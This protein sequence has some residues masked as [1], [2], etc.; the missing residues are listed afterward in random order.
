MIRGQNQISHPPRATGDVDKV[1][2]APPLPAPIRRILYLASEG[3]QQVFHRAPR[4][5]SEP[6]FFKQAFRSS[7]LPAAVAPSKAAH[8][9]VSLTSFPAFR[10]A[11]CS[12]L[13]ASCTL[14][15]RGDSRALGSMYDRVH[16][17]VCLCAPGA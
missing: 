8:L 3:T 14:W 10:S 4:P 1:G 7:S 12:H 13:P 15:L 6:P 5:C 9:I 17:L 11:R 2:G 16:E